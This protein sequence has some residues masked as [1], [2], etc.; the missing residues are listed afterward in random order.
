M[1]DVRT[2]HR[3]LERALALAH[4]AVEEPT[5]GRVA[6]ARSIAQDVLWFAHRCKPPAATLE[7]GHALLHLVHNLRAVLQVLERDQSRASVIS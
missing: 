5:D 4:A 6:D 7:E 1:S 3:C 2:L